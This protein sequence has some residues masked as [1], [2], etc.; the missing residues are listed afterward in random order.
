MII[1]SKIRI[2]KTIYP[3]SKANFDLAMGGMI[4]LI[5]I[6]RS[7]S[8]NRGAVFDDEWFYL[9]IGD[10]NKKFKLLELYGFLSDSNDCFLS[11]KVIKS[12]HIEIKVFTNHMCR[13]EV[14]MSAPN[15]L[16]GFNDSDENRLWLDS[17]KPRVIDSVGSSY[18]DVAYVDGCFYGRSIYL[19]LFLKIGVAYRSEILNN[20]KY[21]VSPNA[22]KLISCF[23]N[24]LSDKFGDF[25]DLDVRSKGDFV[26]QCDEEILAIL[27][28][29]GLRRCLKEANIGMFKWL[30]FPALKYLFWRSQK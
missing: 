16:V 18:F 20:K 29:S 14:V 13:I 22:L 17:I 26:S 12:K 2:V 10:E 7:S 11:L 30:G 28:V 1:I 27:E 24:I 9:N 4:D 3:L 8:K 23:G 5:E 21:S 6:M 15:K 19:Y 25:I